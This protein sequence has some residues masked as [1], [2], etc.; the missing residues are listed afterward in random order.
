MPTTPATPPYFAVAGGDWSS[1]GVKNRLA[2][3]SSGRG[4][5]AVARRGRRARN[6]NL[7]TRRRCRD[8]QRGR[9]SALQVSPEAFFCAQLQRR[10]GYYC[11]SG[12]RRS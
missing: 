8:V 9:R 5:A 10:K 7:E 3:P 1:G 12:M 4:A 11:S 6:N 2:A